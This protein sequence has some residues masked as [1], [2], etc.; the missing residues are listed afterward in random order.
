MNVIGPKNREKIM[1]AKKAA[2]VLGLTAIGQV[3]SSQTG[4]AADDV[5][6]K[7]K[8]V[9]IQI[10]YGSGGSYDVYGRLAA[11]H[12]GAYLPGK[13]N[14][15][16]Q[17]MTGAGSL[18]LANHLYS[19]AP[20]NG[21]VLGVI[22]Q[23]I[24]VDQVLGGAGINFD[25]AKFN[26]V[27]RMASGVE[28]VITWHTVPAKTIDDAKKTTVIIAATG[29]SSGAAIYPTILNNMLGTK[30]KVIRGYDGT[31]EML[32]AMERGEAG[33]CG[34][35]NIAT[36]TSQFAH[37]VKDKKINVLTQV[38]VDRHP[39][40]PDVPTIV[41]LATNEDDKKVMQVFAVSGDI[42]RALTAPPGLAPELVKTMRASFMAMMKDPEL[43]ATAKKANLDIEP[44]DGERLQALIEEVGRFPKAVVDKAIAA[45][46]GP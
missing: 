30:F 13:P 36:L 3:L 8:Q 20:K 7:G 6:F 25:S 32:L 5:D 43:L 40:F 35:I 12:L 41:E 10:G 23:T 16:A 46:Q 34:A 44:M 37:W 2:L 28:T 42:G 17:N 1:D 45:K 33:G 38:S 31:K 14:V 29:P 39:A 18:T 24:P 11:R 21:T 22:G 26:W 19:N 27:G 9:T 15:I 4:F